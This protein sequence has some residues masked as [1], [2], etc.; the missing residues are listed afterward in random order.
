M[1]HIS[2]ILMVLAVS[3]LESLLIPPRPTLLESSQLEA[4]AQESTSPRLDDNSEEN[5]R[6]PNNTAPEAYRIELWTDVHNGDRE[7]Y[8][9]VQIDIEVLEES[10]E[11]KLHYRQ[12]EGFEASIVSRDEVNSTEIPLNVTLDPQREF[13]VLTATETNTSFAANTKWTLTVNYNGTLRSDMAGFHRTSYT[14]D[15][16]TERYLAATQFESTNARHAFPGYDEPARRANFTITIHHDPSYSA[17]SNMPVNESAS[18]LG[19]TAFQTT[20]K[21]STYLVA[22]VV[23]DFGYTAGQLNDLQQRVFTQ[24]G[25]VGQQEWAMWS[26]LVVESSL[27]GYFGIP[28]PLPKLDQAGIPGKG[29]AMENWGLATYGEQYMVWSKENSTIDLK[30]SIANIIGHEYAHMWFGDLVSIQWWTYL[31]LKEGFA[32]LFSY[33]SNDIAFPEWDTYQIYHVSDYN[34]ALL[35]DASTSAVPMTHYVQTPNEI[36]GRYN[37]FSYAKPSAVLYM[38]KNAWTDRVFRAGLN[39]YLTKNQY[40]S[41]DEWDLFAALQ[42]SADEHGLSLPTSVDNIFSSWS[43]KA[44]YPLLTVTR[45][46]ATGTFTVKQQRYLAVDDSNQITWYVPINFATASNPDYRNT[47]ASHYLLNTTEVEISDVAIASEDWIIFNLKSAFYYRTLYDLENYDRIID[48]LNNNH[49]KIHVRN[50]AQLLSDAYIFV[51]TG[52]L[53]H[54]VLL[55]LLTYLK[56]E[57]QYAPWSNANTVLTAY[58]RYLRGEDPNSFRQFVRN[59]VEPVLDRIGVHEIPG[60]HYLRNYLRNIIVS[61]ACQVKSEVCLLQASNKLSE[62]LFN[63]TAIEPSLRTQVYC[64]G[65]RSPTDTV[66]D[67]VLSDLVASTD[68]TDRSLFISS[69]GCSTISGQLDKFFKL[70]TTNSLS[71][72][73]STSLLNS[74]FTKSNEG[75][76]ESLSYLEE[77]WYIYATGLNET[78]KHLDA[79]LREMANYVVGEAEEKRLLALVEEIKLKGPQYLEDDLAAV[80][81]S[82]IQLNYDWLS[83]NRDP[84]M[85]WTADYIYPETSSGT[86]F[87]SS[88]AIMFV[89]ALFALLASFV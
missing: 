63:G 49:H 57:D 89:S 73:E 44:G 48:G 31:W 10:S 59:L 26:G 84:I 37:T 80:I 32:T 79:D 1:W 12:T 11:I 33:E 15:N 39:K 81:E 74:A 41:C 3:S 51:T 22:F 82:R 75:L 4:G 78:N 14:D 83:V 53:S 28:F 2:W 47:S 36:S 45:N 34:S 70:S 9:T 85:N 86:S 46:Y 72:S 64:S 23:S 61:L 65:L 18:S 77:N 6:L 30:T 7:F 20:P 69:L 8:G 71:Y 56:Y 16:G 68:A 24:N 29:G 60:E 13:L 5:Y 62:F 87:K 27:A 58:D 38:F 76:R 40:T 42:E 17:I 54:S 19:V 55:R 50:R 52:R 67:R 43:Q 66:Y 21:M 35:N 88:L 25:K